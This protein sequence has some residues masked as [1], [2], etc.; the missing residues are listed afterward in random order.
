MAANSVA[1]N[2]NQLLKRPLVGPGRVRYQIGW[3]M[4]GSHTEACEVIHV[5]R[6]HEVAA[7]AWYHEDRHTPQDPSDVVGQDLPPAAED[8][9]RP[10][11]RVW[12][13]AIDQRLL[14]ECFAA[15]VRQRRI[16]RGIGNAHVDDSG[17]S[18]T[19]SCLKQS[20]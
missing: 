19:P 4:R 14:D 1:D 20:S 10:H 2:S 5:D 15:V 9:S 8:P 16:R 18:S 11:D 7:I 12:N 3:P 6:L 17:N 13:V